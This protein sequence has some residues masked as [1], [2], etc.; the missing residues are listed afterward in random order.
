VR[1]TGG[2][3]AEWNSRDPKDDKFLE[4]AVNGRADVLVTG[5][6]N[7]LELNPSANDSSQGT[8]VEDSRGGYRARPAGESKA[9]SDSV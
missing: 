4:V 9:E 5:D 6:G 2:K 1:R 3:W 8:I 7:L